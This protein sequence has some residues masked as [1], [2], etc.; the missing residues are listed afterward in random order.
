MTDKELL[1][2]FAAAALPA[3]VTYCGG[4]MEYMCKFLGAPYLAEH[5]QNDWQEIF[6]RYTARLAYGHAIAMMVERKEN[7]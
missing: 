4:E 3:V 1:D 2:H 6:C 7:D 5:T